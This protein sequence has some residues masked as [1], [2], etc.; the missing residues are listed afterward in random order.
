V[1]NGEAEWQH[2][3]L[4][5]TGIGAL[6]DA[7]VISGEIGAAKP[8]PR[9]FHRACELLGVEPGTAIMVGDNP[10]CDIA[11]AEAA[12]LRSSIFIDPDGGTLDSVAHL[13][14]LRAAG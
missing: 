13:L 12:G 8:D 11:G 2:R 7:V 10:Q 1:T 14:A 6:V 3:K 5:V 4:R 9:P